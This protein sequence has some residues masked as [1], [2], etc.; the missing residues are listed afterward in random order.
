MKRLDEILATSEERERAV[1]TW[2]REIRP[3]MA[4]DNTQPRGHVTEETIRE[5]ALVRLAELTRPDEPV[6]VGEALRKVVEAWRDPAHVA[7][8]SLTHT[9][10]VDAP[11]AKDRRA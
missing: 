10:E 6:V 8:E 11:P 9:V 7:L 2:E 3:E 1:A 5:L 4:P